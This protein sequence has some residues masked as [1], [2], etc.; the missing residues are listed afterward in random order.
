MDLVMQ[1]SSRITVLNMGRV[2]TTASPD[3]VRA[4]PEVISAYL[5]TARAVV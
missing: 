2:L 3:E 5:G 4:N 1:V